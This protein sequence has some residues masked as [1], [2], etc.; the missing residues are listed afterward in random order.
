MPA[1]LGRGLESASA[2]GHHGVRLRTWG[3]WDV[4]DA[5]AHRRP[6]G[7]GGGLDVKAG[8]GQGRAC[9]T[10][11]VISDGDDLAGG[12]ADGGEYLVPPGGSSDRYSL[13]DGCPGGDAGRGCEPV[14]EGPGQRGTGCGLYCHDYGQPVDEP[15]LKQFSAAEVGTEHKRAV[16]GRKHERAGQLAAELLPQFED[17]GLGAVQEERVVDVT[18]VE[19][20]WL[21]RCGSSRSG[22]V[23]PGTLNAVNGCTISE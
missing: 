22:G 20:A 8:V 12:F 6:G 17:V 13:G 5:G 9:G 16:A 7:R 18:G 15:L 11:L 4:G 1:S 23:F 3:G 21:V 19:D 2:Q 14:V 10:D